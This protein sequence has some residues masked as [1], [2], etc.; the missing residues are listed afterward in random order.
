L[1]DSVAR[2]L[3]INRDRLIPAARVFECIHSTYNRSIHQTRNIA[4]I[5]PAM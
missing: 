5:A 3:A 2:W 1:P 4:T